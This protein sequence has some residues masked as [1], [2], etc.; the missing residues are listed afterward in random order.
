MNTK[1]QLSAIQKTLNK[2]PRTVE[3]VLSHY[4]VD[5]KCTAIYAWKKSDNKTFDLSFVESVHD[6]FLRYGQASTSQIEAL[7]NILR[8]FKISVTKWCY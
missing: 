3:N 1:A 8:K 4:T 6:H 5:E 2:S 7:D